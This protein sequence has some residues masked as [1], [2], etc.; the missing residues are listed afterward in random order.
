MDGFRVTCGE[1]SARK[2]I[3]N[4]MGIAK[5]FGA[6]LAPEGL[7]EGV[8]CG[9]AAKSG[10]LTLEAMHPVPQEFDPSFR[11]GCEGFRV[12]VNDALR[13]VGEDLDEA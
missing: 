13:S 3:G 4:A 7:V 5:R 1:H 11:I 6:V 2:G 12:V 9:L 8:A 10:R